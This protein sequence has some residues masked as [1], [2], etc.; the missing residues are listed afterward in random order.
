M[1]FPTASA[2]QPAAEQR[3]RLPRHVGI[4]LDGNRRW[5]RR[6][7]LESTADGHRTGF[8]KIPDVLTWCAESGIQFVTLWM[9]S[10]DNIARRSA[11]ELEDLYAIDEGV[12]NR[13]RASGRWRLHHIGNPDLLPRSIVRLLRDAEE[14][15]HRNTGMLVN[16]AIG[17][18]G[19][20]DVLTAV[21]SIIEDVTHGRGVQV[22]E[23]ELANRLST[24]GQPDPE[25]II[26]PSGEF[27]T[28]GFLLWQAALAELYFCDCLWPD[29]TRDDLAQALRSFSE[30]T[31]RLGV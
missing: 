1:N 20:S 15:T 22:T 9:L 7:G 19:R 10:D 13:L 31:R 16:L 5:A 28:S 23:E 6:N 2:T 18:G 24:A 30:R 14:D 3:T 12:I 29:F 21:R 25:F 27:R 26:R 8:D 4:V 11:S 17:Y